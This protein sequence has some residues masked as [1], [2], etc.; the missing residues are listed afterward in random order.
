MKYNYF[1][2]LLYVIIRRYL[3][4]NNITIHHFNDNNNFTKLKVMKLLFLMVVTDANIN[5]ERSILL[6]V[7]NN[8]V[9]MKYGPVELDIYNYIGD[10]N[11]QQVLNPNPVFIEINAN[12]C[13]INIDIFNQMDEM[14]HNEQIINMEQVVASMIRDGK[15]PL[16][17]SPSTLVD[18]THNYASWKTVY[19]NAKLN[20]RLFE[21]MPS[22]LIANDQ[23]YY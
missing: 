11:N 14:D 21:R 5:N 17:F 12:R 7:F 18:V 3:N 19:E 23:I 22:F 16:S 15:N 9:A 10:V 4:D 13:F 2:W 1:N 20:K 6:D 8:F